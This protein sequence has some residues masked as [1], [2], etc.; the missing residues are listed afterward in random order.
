MREPVNTWTHFISFLLG[1]IGLG[2]LIFLSHNNTPKLIT[3]TIYGVSLVLLYGASTLYHWVNITPK[4]EHILRTLDHISIFLLI[5]G[6]YTPIL[7]FGLNGPWK[8][9][10]LAVVWGLAVMGVVLKVFFTGAHRI[11]STLFYLGLGWIA[12]VP[13]FKLVKNLPKGAIVLMFLGGV[14]Y[15]IGGIIYATKI[16]NFIPDKFGFHEIFHIFI[17]LGSVFHFVMILRFIVPI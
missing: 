17:S 3:M 14:A 5:A 8:W 4:G 10:M 9:T 2:V 11:I 1:V 6:T 15:T 13:L 12:V 16:F 7:Y